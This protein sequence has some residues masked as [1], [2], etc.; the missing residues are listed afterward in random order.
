MAFIAKNPYTGKVIKEIAFQS[1][2]EIKAKISKLHDYYKA[3]KDSDVAYRTDKLRK[4]EKMLTENSDAFARAISTNM[5]KPITQANIEVLRGIQATQWNAENVERLTSGTF[6]NTE[7]GKSGWRYKPTGIIYKIAPFNFPLIL[8]LKNVLSN[9][10]VGNASLIRPAQTCPD[11]GVLIEELSQKYGI[12]GCEVLYN[13][14]KD[15]D[16]ILEDERVTGISFT[17]STNA[18]R[19]IAEAA[20]RHL[21]KSVL[22]LGGMDAFVV[23]QDADIKE[24]AITAAKGRLA[25]CG[26]ICISP[27]RFIIPEEMAEDFISVVKTEVSNAKVGDP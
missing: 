8:V 10:V 15:L 6:K 20:G 14:P 2:P 9:F 4:V 1:R 3:T 7:N 27:K 5:G 23:L 13:D 19:F 26:Q 22:E 24:T 17:G 25:N 21:K 12:S 11:I 16:F 18:G